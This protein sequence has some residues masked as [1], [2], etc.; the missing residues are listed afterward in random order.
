MDLSWIGNVVTAIVASGV[1]LYASASTERRRDKR[2]AVQRA[3][4]DDRAAE[5]AEKESRASQRASV[6]RLS[7]TFLKA[8]E[9]ADAS[10]I[11]YEPQPDFEEAFP[12]SWRKNYYASMRDAEYVTDTKTRIIFQDCIQAIYW[13]DVLSSV[14][15]YGSA[16]EIVR[17]SASVG[18]VVAGFWGRGEAI[19]ADAVSR[20]KGVSNLLESHQKSIDNEQDEARRITDNDLL[21]SRRDQPAD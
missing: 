1:T 17:N 14:A 20:A 5:Q 4:D 10:Q 16:R 18:F 8:R 12:E 7:K 15:G 11:Y 13:C 21:T 2:E 6:E 9:K 3:A 19:D